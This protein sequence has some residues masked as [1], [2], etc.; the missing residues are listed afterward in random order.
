MVEDGQADVEGGDP[1]ALGA[2]QAQAHQRV[3]QGERL[4]RLRRVEVLALRLLHEVEARAHD[5]NAV[6]GAGGEKAALQRVPQ[7]LVEGERGPQRRVEGDAAVPEERRARGHLLRGVADRADPR[8]LGRER[9]LLAPYARHGVEQ[10]RLDRAPR[11]VM[12]ALRSLPLEDRARE[13]EPLV[14]AGSGQ[15]VA[16]SGSRRRRLRRVLRRDAA[17]APRRSAAAPS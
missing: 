6:D 17:R 9:R 1:E 12:A 5:R 7:G 16:R 10:P 2:R 15:R 13:P 4:H 8:E 14:A 3:G 11:S